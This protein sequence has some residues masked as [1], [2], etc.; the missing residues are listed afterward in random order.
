MSHPLIDVIYLEGSDINEDG[1]LKSTVHNSKP[2]IVMV[3]G[4]FC[5][6]CTDA[7]P[8]FQ[9]LAQMNSNVTC[10]TIQIDGEENDKQ[11]ALKFKKYGG[12]GVPTYFIFD[13]NGKFLQQYNGGRDFSSLNTFC[14]T[15]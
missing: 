12:P 10:C 13:R 7:K 11:A 2:V 5:H 1:S 6:F 14:N 9:K 15:L 8:D 4:N 3:Q